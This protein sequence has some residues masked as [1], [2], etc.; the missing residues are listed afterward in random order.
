[1]PSTRA[2]SI[3]AATHVFAL[4]ELC[5]IIAQYSG[6]GGA[7]FKRVCKTTRQGAGEWLVVC[8]GCISRSP[9]AV[10]TRQVWRLDLGEL[11]WERMSDL[12][13]ERTMHECCAVREGV[14]ALGGYVVGQAGLRTPRERGG[15]G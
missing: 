4:A 14:V 12:T 1:M 7:I 6:V 5:A 10:F 9:P 13:C 3:W 15:F 11:R 2:V 8:G